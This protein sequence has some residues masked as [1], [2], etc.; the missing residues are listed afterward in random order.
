[1][2]P[3]LL[4]QAARERRLGLLVS[5]VVGLAAVVGAWAVATYENSPQLGGFGGLLFW[6]SVTLLATAA[7]VRMAGGTR[8][9]IHCSRACR[10]SPWWT[11]RRSDCRRDRNT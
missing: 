4:I 8:E 10:C 7:P 6:V 5:G 11:E 3:H 2:R 1:M 9:R